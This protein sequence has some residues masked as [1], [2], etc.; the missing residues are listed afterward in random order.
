MHQNASTTVFAIPEL[1]ENILLQLGKSDTRAWKQLFPVQGVNSTFQAIIRESPIL[2]QTMHLEQ[3]HPRRTPSVKFADAL[4]LYQKFFF[5][6]GDIMYP[7]WS[8]IR[9][10]ANPQ[11]IVLGMNI[12]LFWA[13]ELPGVVAG[14][15]PGPLDSTMPIERQASWRGILVPHHP[16]HHMELHC[17]GYDL[18]VRFERTTTLGELADRAI[19]AGRFHIAGLEKVM[20]YGQDSYELGL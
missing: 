5:S 8:H 3:P 19:K 15:P 14:S 17:C 10:L 11:T 2:R 16:E 12:S 4:D 20:Y 1:A 18:M 9:P 6:L 13:D 7:F